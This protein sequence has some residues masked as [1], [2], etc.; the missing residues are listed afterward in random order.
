MRDDVVV[1]LRKIFGHL[2]SLTKAKARVRPTSRRALI[3][4]LPPPSPP[5]PGNPQSRRL[6]GDIRRDRGALIVKRTVDPRGAKAPLERFHHGPRVRI[7][8]A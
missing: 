6:R 5:Q 1:G 4:K 3:T 2:T 7:K 8:L